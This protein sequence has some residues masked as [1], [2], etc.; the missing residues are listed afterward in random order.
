MKECRLRFKH[1]DQRTGTICF[2]NFI[3]NAITDKDFFCE[4]LKEIENEPVNYTQMLLEALALNQF[5]MGERLSCVFRKLAYEKAALNQN[6]V[7][8]M[9]DLMG[10]GNAN[11][12]L[13]DLKERIQSYQ[14]PQRSEVT[15]NFQEF[16]AFCHDC[17][18]NPPED[19]ISG[20]LF[21]HHQHI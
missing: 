9:L 7:K 15:L 10:S 19:L 16:L 6:G 5:L 13:G 17:N 1:L 18:F 20:T 2:K 3:D 12:D 21:S 11:T 14:I 4:E 8:Q